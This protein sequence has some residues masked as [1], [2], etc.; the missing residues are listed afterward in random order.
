MDINLWR[1][2]S[3]LRKQESSYIVA[4]QP[5]PALVINSFRYVILAGCHVCPLDILAVGISMDPH[6][7][8]MPSLW[9]TGR[10]GYISCND[11]SYQTNILII[12]IFLGM[13]LDIA[14][15]VDTGNILR[16]GKGKSTWYSLP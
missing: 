7:P 12:W 11:N 5:L 10:W 2:M 9:R 4:K 16:F 6:L 13:K 8:P 15:L 14:P 1:N 3:F